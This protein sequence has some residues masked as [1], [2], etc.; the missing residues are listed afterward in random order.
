MEQVEFSN[1]VVLNKIDLVNEEQQADIWDRIENL[2]PKAKVLKSC[3]SKINVLEILNTKLFSKS[4]MEE[5]SIIASAT[6]V[7]AVEKI[8]KVKTE[9]FDPCCKKSEDEGGKK[10]CKS[11][12]K[13]GQEINSGLSQ[14]LLGVVSSGEKVLTR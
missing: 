14:I 12:A 4:D 11:K 10:C 3:Q 2:N 8:E 13:N 7:E 6:R 1:V 9:D 5:N